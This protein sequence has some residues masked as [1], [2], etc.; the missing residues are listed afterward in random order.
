MS[1]AA[2]ARHDRP[3]TYGLTGNPAIHARNASAANAD[4]AVRLDRQGD[5]AIAP[6]AAPLR[7]RVARPGLEETAVTMEHGDG[8]VSTA[9][10]RV[11]LDAA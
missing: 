2:E 3:A 10:Y 5:A 6:D 11:L 1:T 9:A 7:R 4:L 8:A